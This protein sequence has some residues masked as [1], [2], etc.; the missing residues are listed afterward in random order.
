MPPVPNSCEPSTLYEVKMDRRLRIEPEISA[1][2]TY[3]LPV[4]CDLKCACRLAYTEIRSNQSE[5][6]PEMSARIAEIHFLFL[7]ICNNF[8]NSNLRTKI[9]QFR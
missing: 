1:D 8:N 4:C 7:Y 3:S 2:F 5:I 6:L 9:I